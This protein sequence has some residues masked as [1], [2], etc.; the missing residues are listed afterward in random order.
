MENLDIKITYRSN[1]PLLCGIQKIWRLQSDICLVC[2]CG[3]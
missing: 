2:R 1:A 3:R